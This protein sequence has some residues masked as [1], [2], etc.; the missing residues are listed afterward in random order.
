MNELVLQVRE[1]AF[2]HY[3]V[4]SAAF[5]T[6]TGQYLRACHLG[7]ISLTAIDGAPVGVVNQARLRA[8]DA[9]LPY[10][11]HPM[12]TLRWSGF[13]WISLQLCVSRNQVTPPDKANRP[14][15]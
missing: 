3:I 9:Q 14:V 2:S 4:V 1:E 6:H 11:A 5:R 10:S 7:T 8:R 15:S 12:S 13:P